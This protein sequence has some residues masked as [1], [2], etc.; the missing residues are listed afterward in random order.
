MQPRGFDDRGYPR[1]D[2][3]IPISKIRQ[4]RSFILSAPV[5]HHAI[6]VDSFAIFAIFAETEYD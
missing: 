2:L 3:Q 6:S 5:H 1:M 4:N